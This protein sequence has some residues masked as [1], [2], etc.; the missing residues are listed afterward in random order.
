MVSV[1]CFLG[2]FV[3]AWGAFASDVRVVEVIVAKV[4]NEIITSSELERGRRLIEAQLRRSGTGGQ[5]LE[6]AV[7]E[8]TKDVL[9]DRIDQLL[10]VQKGK[11]LEI[12]VDSEVTK[13][14]ANIQ[15]QNKIA[16]QDKFQQWIREQSGMPFE[17]FKAE[18]RN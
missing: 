2:T 17:D 13:E 12:N 8:R 7:K 1:L 14:L 18:M 4:N 3:L 11:D 16:D 9:R 6:E 15:L 5:Q 10:L